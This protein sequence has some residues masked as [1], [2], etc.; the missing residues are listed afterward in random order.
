[1]C[2]LFQETTAETLRNDFE[3]GQL[4]RDQVISHAVLFF[5]GEAADDFDDFTA[6]EDEDLVSGGENNL[7]TLNVYRV[8]QN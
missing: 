7:S 1:M 3:I 2:V 6:D 4:I 8:F 5:T